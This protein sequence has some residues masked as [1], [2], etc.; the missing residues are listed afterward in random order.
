MSRS[1]QFVSIEEV[2]QLTRQ[3][4]WA[5]S[6]SSRFYWTLAFLASG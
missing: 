5:G 4:S 2:A 1:A 6:H 3:W